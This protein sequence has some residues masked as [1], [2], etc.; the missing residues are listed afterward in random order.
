L[1]DADKMRGMSEK[2]VG[3]VVREWAEDEV[4]ELRVVSGQRSAPL[5]K[6]ESYSLGIL[7]AAG[8]GVVW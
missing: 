5:E 4:L 8:K 6:V 3:V 2:K 7:G 1:L